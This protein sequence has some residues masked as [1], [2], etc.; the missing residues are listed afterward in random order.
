MVQNKNLPLRGSINII[1]LSD[2]KKLDYVS[3]H[4]HLD[5]VIEI[6]TEGTSLGKDFMK[7]VM[8]KRSL[9]CGN[10]DFSYSYLSGNSLFYY[11]YSTCI[12]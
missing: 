2:Y 10:H 9:V 5:T 11:M 6:N 4:C 8:C 1:H 7:Q 12:R 3:T